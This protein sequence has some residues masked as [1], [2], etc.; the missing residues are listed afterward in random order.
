MRA[1]R[2]FLTAADNFLQHLKV[3]WL[4]QVRIETRIPGTL[5]IFGLPVTGES[6]DPYCAAGAADALCNLIAVHVR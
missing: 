6:D 5:Q 3:H 1:H 4:D 2:L